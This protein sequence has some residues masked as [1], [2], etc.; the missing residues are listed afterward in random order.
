MYNEYF[1]LKKNPFSIA[2]DP[3]FFYI[4][5]KH[6]EALGHLLY[7]FNSEGGFVLLTG[8]VG[9]G[10]T[11]VLRRLLEKAPEDC[12]IAFIL[13]PKLTGEELLAAICDEF[14]ISHPGD[15][16][17][18]R[19]LV[20]RIYDYL[21]KTHE[22]GRRAV[23]IIEEA[24]NLSDDVLEQIR[25]LTNLETNTRK[26]LQV[27]MLGQ[28]E[29]RD[30]LAKPSFRQLTQRITAR[31][32]LTPL[33]FEDTGNYINHRLSVA[34][35]PKGGLFPRP[36]LRK[37]FR[38][39]NGVPRLIN[40][41]C[42]RALAGAYIEGKER[43]SGKIL[44]AAAREVSGVE[45]FSTFQRKAVGIVVAS[46]ILLCVGGG[47]VYY[48]GHFVHQ[49][50]SA[51]ILQKRATEVPGNAT[52]AKVDQPAKSFLRKNGGTIDDGKDLVDEERALQA[53]L[54]KWRIDLKV[55]NTAQTCR[56]VR[57]LGLSCFEGKETLDAVKG[58]N[59]PAV[60]KLKDSDN[61]DR[62]T[63]VT[64]IGDE[65]VT[66]LTA[67]SEKVVD[68]KE[69]ARR[70]SGHYLLLWRLPPGQKEDIAV[71]DRGPLV[72]WI[73]NQLAISEGREA[74]GGAGQVYTAELARQVR[75]FQVAA[76]LVPDGRVGPK[77]LI[78]L[79]NVTATNE[80]VLAGTHGGR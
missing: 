55:R 15:G 61:R 50:V 34:G 36:V 79:S 71:G 22:V 29:F 11:T 8:E 14:G 25:L 21:V 57:G 53:L 46:L 27:I 41:L 70:W 6:R 59:R 7:A 42:D 39:T 68:I 4:S 1:G 77:T 54:G 56:Y 38:L 75:Q 32:H 78:R 48:G 23:L 43:V 45:A 49:P 9:T 76:G 5:E 17:S 64:S 3:A 12:D 13:Y 69:L 73:A 47:I 37:L 35:L 72:A 62:Y 28:P 19:L 31:Y 80:P 18:S 20:S 66:L 40:V 65:T 16:A 51:S 26:L 60:L 10:K 58:M 33:S 52:A 24:Q 67:D 74:S 30:R 44:T 63:V 2:P